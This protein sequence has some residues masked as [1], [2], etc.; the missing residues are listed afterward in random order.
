M[1]SPCKR[2]K[3]GEATTA[4]PIPMPNMNAIR[5]MAKTCNEAP[6]MRHKQRE[7]NTSS[8]IETPPVRATM[9][10]APRKTAGSTVA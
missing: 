4:L 7:A 9:M 6:N 10:Q 3:R 5:T 1:I 8:P 2:L